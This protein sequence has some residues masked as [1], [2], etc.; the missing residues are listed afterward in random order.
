MALNASIIQG[1]RPAQIA[2]PPDPIESYGKALQLKSLMGQQ[3]LQA[4]QLEEAQR[5]NDSQKKLRD[6]FAGI[7]PGED[8]STKLPGVF[9]IDP[10]TGL[11]MQKSLR[12][13]D[14]AKAT[15]EKTK[16]ETHAAQAKDF[17]DYI[18][19]IGPDSYDPNT[20]RARAARNF[21]AETAAQMKIPDTFDPNWQRQS[22]MTG[23]KYLESIAPKLNVVNLGGRSQFVETNPNAPGFNAGVD[24]THTA[25]PGEV[26]AGRHNTVTE[27]QGGQRLALEGQNVNLRRLAVD[28]FGIMGTQ[29]I[30][31]GGGAIGAPASIPGPGA[32][33]QAGAAGVPSVTPTAAPARP[34][35]PADRPVAQPGQP[36]QT[37]ILAGITP[38]THGD[39]FLS[40]LPPA[41]AG[42]VKALAEGRMAFPS[43]M[44]LHSPVTQQLL[45]MVSQYDPTFDAVNYGARNATRKAF[46]SGQ[47]SKSLNAANTVLGHMDEFEKAAT[48]L[49]NTDY[50]LLNRAMNAVGGQVSPDLKG[51]LNQFNITKQAVVSE[52]ERAYRGSGGSQADIEAWKQSLTDADSPQAIRAAIQQGVK[53]LGS[54]IEALGEQYNKGMGTTEDGFTLLNPKARETYQRL[55]GGHEAAG[56][57][58]AG[59]N[60]APAQPVVMDKLPDPAQFKGKVMTDTATNTKY[61]SDGKSWKRQ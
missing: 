40:K 18:A 30:G 46:T 10:T 37:G 38:D 35:Q 49:N 23:D 20:I 15:L 47:E 60:P 27:R 17:R 53:L 56:K 26:E 39:E 16:V 3:D 52:L 33:V 14:Q 43:G 44:G 24:L 6:L 51:R 48:A 19:S 8:I 58:T 13:Q 41:V 5:Q 1:L 2:P 59:T 55:S 36:G 34:G 29:P 4:V 7:Q 42:Q 45:G 50:P 54:K 21:G 12:E 57:V 25:T 22:V 9:A 61:V 11:A 28:P 31:A 32:P